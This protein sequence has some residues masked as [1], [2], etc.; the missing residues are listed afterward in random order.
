MSALGVKAQSRKN[1]ANFSLFQQYFNPALTGYEGSLLKT[2]FR[3]QWT[4]F[5][6]SPR[7]LFISGE[8][9]LRQLQAYK[10]NLA[11]GADAAYQPGG[12]GSHALGFSF[13]LDQFG[14]LQ[15]HQLAVSY[16]TGVRLS[17]KLSLRLG[18]AFS[19]EVSKMNTWKMT[20]D[21]AN[22]PEYTGF[23]LDD[24]RS[25]KLD[26]NMGVALSAA[27][28][29]I[30]YALQDIGQGQVLSGNEL[31]KDLYPRQQVVQ[32]GYRRGL[33]DQ[34]GLVFNGIYRY[35]KK[36][37]ATIEGQLKAVVN[38]TFWA[39]MGY[40]RDQAFSFLGGV[41][42]EPLRLGY[43]RE[44]T[45]G[46]AKGINGSTNEV[47]LTYQLVPLKIEKLTKKLSIW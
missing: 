33:T 18:G 5:E 23:M 41:Q 10:N 29:Y 11:S 13:L 45:S 6:D 16:G 20:L 38:N 30:G 2:F 36:V 21:E 42:L 8:L 22:D 44:M 3:D 40:R 17:E 24:N 39:G 32:A 43:A 7:T 31:L 15:Q 46:K 27:D 9:D 35:D 26:G 19:Y 14:P 25:R 37:K 34:F 12:S 4:G 28:Y 1:V 47:M